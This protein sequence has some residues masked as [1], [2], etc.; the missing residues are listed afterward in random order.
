MAILIVKIG[1]LQFLNN[2][3]CYWNK[4]KGFE[5]SV[6]CHSCEL[7]HQMHPLISSENINI[8]Q[9]VS[10]SLLCCIS[11]LPTHPP[12]EK[13]SVQLLM[14]PLLSTGHQ[15]MSSAWSLMSCSTPSSLDKLML[16][17]SI[18]I[19]LLV[20]FPFCFSVKQAPLNINVCQGQNEKIFSGKI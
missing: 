3:S 6:G 10:I 17:V 8:L 15:M 16:L 19:C 13:S 14:I 9:I 12:F 2:Q 20:L 7:M 4:Q 1:L 5:N 11:Q 18:N